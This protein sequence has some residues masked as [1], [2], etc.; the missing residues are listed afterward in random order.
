MIQLKKPLASLAA[1]ATLAAGLVAGGVVSTASAADNGTVTVHLDQTGCTANSNNTDCRMFHGS[2]GF[3][4]GLTDDGVPSDTT[5]NGLSLGPDSVMVGRSPDGVQHPNGDVMNTTDQWKRNGGGEI[6]VYMKEAYRNFPY[7][8]YGDGGMD[9]DYVPKIKTMV[10]KFNDAFPQYKDDV[11]WIPFNEPDISDANYYNLTNYSSKYDSVRTT[12]FEDWDKA[13]KA[14]RE[15]YPKARIGGPN[16]S[17]YND[18]FYRDFFQ[19]AKENGTVPDVVTWHELGSGFGSYLSNYQKWK[20]LEKDILSDYTAPEGTAL[21]KGQTLKVSINEYAW[22]DKNGTAI[23]QVKPGRLLQYIARFEK[24]GAQG[25]LPYWYPA[26]DLD[27]LVTHNNQVTGSWWL[28][29]WYGLMKGDLLTVDLA[30][31]N[32]KPQALASYDKDSN[33]MQMLLGGTDYSSYSTKV[34][35]T[36]MADKYPNGAHVTVYGVDATAP[37]DLSNVAVSVPAASDG[38]YV[39]AEQD[40]DVT[41]GNATFTLDGLK[42]DS[43]YYAVVT[44]A[45]SESK[46]SKNTV[47]AEYARRNGTATVTYGDGSGYS[48]TGYVKGADKTASSDFFVNSTKDGYSELTLRYSAPKA[49]GLGVTRPVQLKI[50]RQDTVT[51]DLPQTRDSNTWQTVKVRAYLPLGLSQITVEGYGEQGVLIDSLGVAGAD[52][53]DVT[54]Y[55]AES[56]DNTFGGSAKASNNNNASGMRIVG[57]VGNGANNTLTFNKVNAPADGDYTVTIGYAQWQY[58]DNNTWQIE[59]RWADMSVNGGDSQRVVFANTRSWDNFWT[60]SVRVTLR[61]G[62][63]TIRFGNATG[64]APNF[65]YIQVAPT[66]AGEPRYATADGSPVTAITGLKASADGLKD[67]VL[68]MMEGDD[69]TVD[70]SIEPYTATDPELTWTSSD[71]S[72]ATVEPVKDAAAPKARAI[73]LIDSATVHAVK[74]G[75]TTIT[76][77]PAANPSTVTTTFTVKVGAKAS[78]LNAVPTISGADDVTISVGDVFDPKAGVTASDA[79]EGNLTGAIRIEGSV[80]TSKAGTYVL[81]YTVADSQGATA[82]VKRTVTV[83]AKPGKDDDNKP[84][85]TSG[86]GDQSGAKPGSGEGAK[87]GAGTGSGDTTGASDAQGE[88]AG[89]S[90]TGAGVAVVAVVAL[91]AVAGG[92]TLAVRRRTMR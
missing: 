86:S 66:V 60:T 48:G 27:W 43:V 14:I 42:G 58:A 88:P 70:V 18:K 37:A 59:N 80:D 29:Y 25:A 57:N 78:T 82:T 6:Q 35:L 31:E 87:P 65:D 45:T 79:E 12:F 46:V 22:K 68:T 76:V 52:D 54:R 2:T 4:Y 69:A 17:G 40:L 38:P 74:A 26:G 47:E 77:A 11:V 19:H 55:E 3:L 75:E 8:A 85:T 53:S 33:Q 64:W 39:V 9:G 49:D 62:E 32:G 91:L 1:V 7:V 13:V 24:T 23:E 21:Q 20:T 36:A 72:V 28:Y 16:N 71:P 50:N 30:D 89:L 84:G 15:V 5:V 34:N 92:L 56:Y 90:R 83:K 10:A 63:N 73:R 61:K 44:P 51:L 81:T 67:G 41:G